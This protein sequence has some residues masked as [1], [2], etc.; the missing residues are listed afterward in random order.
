MTRSEVPLQQVGRV[1]YRAYTDPAVYEREQERIF[2][3]P[4]W[5]YVALS[6]E[7]PNPGDFKQSTIGE[8]PVVVV[9]N[10]AGDLVVFANRCAHRG[11]QFCREGIGN[12]KWFMCPYHHWTY[13]L[14]GNLSSIPFRLGLRGLGGMPESFCLDEHGLERLAVA[15]RHGVVFASFGHGVEPFDEYLGASMLGYFDRVF[16]GRE[17][18][19]LGYESQRVPANWKLMFE[20]IKDPYHAVCSTCSS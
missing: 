12:V 5:N 6:C 7:V 8:K 10:E 4:A 14:E 13:D 9:R 20:N 1:P 19:V 11:V 17:L 15:E 2:S 3:G 16:D 18:R